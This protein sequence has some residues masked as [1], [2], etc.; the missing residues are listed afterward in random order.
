MLI[1]TYLLMNISKDIHPIVDIINSYKFVIILYELSLKSQNKILIF[2][3]FY[4]YYL[5]EFFIK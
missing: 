4:I 5:I 3:L 2:Y 1:F